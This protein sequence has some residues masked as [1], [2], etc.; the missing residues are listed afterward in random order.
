MVPALVKA[1]VKAGTL[2]RVVA[3]KCLCSCPQR[4]V[5][6][7]LQAFQGLLKE[8]GD[9]VFL[10]HVGNRTDPFTQA[11]QWVLDLVST[12]TPQLAFARG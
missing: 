7:I 3:I 6:A 5:P 2:D 11:F 12:P 1:G 8:G 10:E 9:L 4:E